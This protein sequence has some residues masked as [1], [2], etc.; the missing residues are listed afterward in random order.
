M[1]KREK[2]IRTSGGM[3]KRGLVFDMLLN[4]ATNGKDTISGYPANPQGGAMKIPIFAPV[5]PTSKP[6]EPV[7]PYVPA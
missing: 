7:I 6:D 4:Y 1:M 2:T 3:L 5:K